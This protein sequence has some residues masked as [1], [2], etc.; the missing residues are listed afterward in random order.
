MATADEPSSIQQDPRLARPGPVKPT[1]ATKNLGKRPKAPDKRLPKKGSTLPPRNT[2]ARTQAE[3][4]ATAEVIEDHERAWMALELRK[5]G[6]SFKSIAER[7]GYADASGARTAIRNLID[8][9]DLESARE[10][11][12][13]QAE[14]LHTLLMGVWSKAKD[15]NH[16]QHLAAVDRARGLIGDIRAMFA[17]DE[18]A[19]AVSPEDRGVLEIGAGEASF[20]QVM[21]QI[22]N[23]QAAT[24]AYDE[25]LDDVAEKVERRGTKARAGGV[26]PSQVIDL[27]EEASQETP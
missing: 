5:A 23:A 9:M 19:D 6:A 11:Q 15:P 4:L 27:S 17:L 25:L 16:P 2:K 14:R 13:I 26:I 18:Q 3:R 7:L 20:V 22:R 10:L 1:N 12:I 21:E 8:R 24:T